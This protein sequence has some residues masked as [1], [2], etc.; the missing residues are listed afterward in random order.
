[1]MT[2]EV[3]RKTMLSEYA[4]FLREAVALVASEPM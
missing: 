3:V 2:G 4:D 1:M